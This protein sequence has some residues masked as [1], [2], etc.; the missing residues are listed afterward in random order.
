[1]IEGHRKQQPGD[2]K[3]CK[4]QLIV[5]NS[6]QACK[7]KHKDNQFSS[8]DINGDCADEKALLTLKQSAARRTMMSYLKRRL[9]D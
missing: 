9:R 6:Q 2:E 5:A 8:D 1:M 3:H 7:V 4:N